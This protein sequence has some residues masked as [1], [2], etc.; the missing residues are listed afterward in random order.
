MTETILA[1][2]ESTGLGIFSA[3]KWN[4]QVLISGSVDLDPVWAWVW[5]P[6]KFEPTNDQTSQDTTDI[7]SDGYKSSTVTSTSEDVTMEGLVK[8]PRVAGE[9]TV[10]EGLALIRSKRREVGDDNVITLRYWRKDQLDADAVIQE[11]SVSWK[12]VGGTNEDNQKFTA[13]LKGQ[14][15]PRF[16]E[17]PKQYAKV[18]TV[19]ATITSIIL[20]L[21]GVDAPPIDNDPLA[22][23][24][25]V[26]AGIVGHVDFEV[27]DVLVDG[28]AGGPWTVTF[29]KD[30]GSLAFG[31]NVGTGTPTWADPA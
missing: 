30:P 22:A 26:G 25:T 27:G 17:R 14:G 28:P 1:Q 11:F 5:G 3:A 21:G 12:D 8:G 16:V 10:G 31:T 7:H 18:L 6:S 23:A 2:P 24:V 9:V 20:K 15:K 13:D 29:A 19:P 4:I